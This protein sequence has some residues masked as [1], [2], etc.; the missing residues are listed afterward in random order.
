MVL[1]I[2]VLNATTGDAGLKS[3]VSL[4]AI[5]VYSILIASELLAFTPLI[6]KIFSFD[7]P[8]IQIREK[9]FPRPNKELLL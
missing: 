2:K 4:D 6:P 1:R 7:F 8:R 3:L 5:R 9:T